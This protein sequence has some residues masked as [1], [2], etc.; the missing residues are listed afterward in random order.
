M[1]SSRP[2]YPWKNVDGVGRAKEVNDDDRP[3]R[4]DYDDYELGAAVD[5]GGV[6]DGF[7]GPLRSFA[8]YE[9][10]EAVTER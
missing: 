5:E 7:L 2:I 8:D 9:D 4:F 6:D 1:K 10:I 3:F